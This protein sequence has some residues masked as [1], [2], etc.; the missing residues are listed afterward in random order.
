MTGLSLFDLLNMD[1]SGHSILHNSVDSIILYI[2][3]YELQLI[4]HFVLAFIYSIK[5]QIPSFVLFC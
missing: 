1:T 3:L 2:S 4:L 5:N